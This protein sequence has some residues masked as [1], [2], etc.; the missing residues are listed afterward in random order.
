MP[1]ATEPIAV[2]SAG[3]QQRDAKQSEFSV[4]VAEFNVFAA[5]LTVFAAELTVFAAEL[6]V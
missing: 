4:Y 1:P 3:T 5:E 2:K 6:T